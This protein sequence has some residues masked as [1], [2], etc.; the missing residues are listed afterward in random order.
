MINKYV[1]ILEIV[2]VEFIALLRRKK[3]C[4]RETPNL[5]NGAG[6]STNIFVSAGVKKG[7][8]AAVAACWTHELIIYGCISHRVTCSSE[9]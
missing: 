2:L 5:S 4:I 6:G 8:V 7:A 1:K 3:F 9:G